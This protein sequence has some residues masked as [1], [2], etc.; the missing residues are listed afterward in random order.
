MAGVV[1]NLRGGVFL[2]IALQ[3]IEQQG[4]IGKS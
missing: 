3:E 1:R 4:G 2:A